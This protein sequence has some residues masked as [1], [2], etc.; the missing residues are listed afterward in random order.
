MLTTVQARLEQ[1]SN[2]SDALFLQ[3]YFKTGP[4]EYGE[5]DRF[6]GIRMPPLRALAREFRTLPLP[7]VERLLRSPFHEDR[8]LALLMLVLHFS[9]GA[10]PT[11]ATVYQL[12]LRA[13]AHINNWDLVDNSA[14]AI[15]GGYLYDKDRA[16]LYTLARSASLW[17]RR[18]ALV[19]TFYFLRKG[20]FR[21]SLQLVELLLTD[22]HDLIHKAMGWVL[23]E[24]GKRNQEA[25]EEFL[26]AQY[27]RLPRTTLRYAIERFPEP[28]RQAYLKGRV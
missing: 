15:V 5:G 3:R 10:P 21:D 18:I 6:R 4:G 20:E 16:P 25:E 24:I 23:R 17:E 12:Y 13:T 8:M 14:P 11:Q 7:E 26:R 28:L 22:R 1:A 9:K 27:R 19:A 2:P